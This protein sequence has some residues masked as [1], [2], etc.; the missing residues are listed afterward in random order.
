[1]VT[2]SLTPDSTQC[3][4]LQ[5]LCWPDSV[6]LNLYG[7]CYQFWTSSRI[8]NWQQ[9][10]KFQLRR[11]RRVITAHEDSGVESGGL[12]LTHIW[13]LQC[14][15]S[16][17]SINS[18]AITYWLLCRQYCSLHIS[19]VILDFGSGTSGIWQ[20]CGNPAKSGSAQISS[21]ICRIWQIPK[22]QQYIHL[23][24]YKTNAPDLSS[25]IH[26]FN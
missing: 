12:M 13:C 8:H 16:T 5:S 20:F 10:S 7:C 23:I 9:L 25:G 26:N 3:L 15:I 11:V 18:A 2:V 14:P 1:M 4:M 24:M 17:F 21:W 22:P 6:Q 19:K